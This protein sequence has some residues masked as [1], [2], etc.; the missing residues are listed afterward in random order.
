[1]VG[2]IQRNGIRFDFEMFQLIKCTTLKQ[3]FGFGSVMNQ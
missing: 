3:G 1:M 2:V